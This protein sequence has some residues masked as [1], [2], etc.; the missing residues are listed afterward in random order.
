MA[1]RERLPESIVSLRQELQ[2]RQM[3]SRKM[4][5]RALLKKLN[6]ANC[7]QYGAGAPPHIKSDRRSLGPNTVSHRTV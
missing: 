4:V 7:Q 6:E 1:E 5:A 3:A 2:G